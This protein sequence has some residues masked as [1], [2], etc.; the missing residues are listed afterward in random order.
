MKGTVP[1]HDQPVAM[2]NF[3]VQNATG[4]TKQQVVLSGSYKVR[5]S[6]AFLGLAIASGIL[7]PKGNDQVAA[8][9]LSNPEP[10]PAM[11]ASS[12]VA[13][14]SQGYENSA[15]E[16][17][18]SSSDWQPSL[19]KTVSGF[20]P[21]DNPVNPSAHADLELAKP[22]KSSGEA[23]SQPEPQ[24]PVAASESF[25][26]SATL[27]NPSSE[28]HLQFSESNPAE[29]QIAPTLE[30][31][32]TVS[33][34]STVRSYSFSTRQQSSETLPFNPSTSLSQ[35]LSGAFVIP[36]EA[37]EPE[38]GVVYQV[39][40]GDTLDKI[41]QLHDVSVEAI[42]QANRITDP[43]W[44]R[45]NQSLKIP[46]Q[47]ASSFA[48]DLSVP[49]TS[50]G[51]ELP[52]D[53]ETSRSSYPVSSTTDFS[54]LGSRLPQAVAPVVISS[55]A[56][57]QGRDISDLS[58]VPTS[59]TL[60]KLS[61]KQLASIQDVSAVESPV[62]VDSAAIS[63]VGASNRL[64]ESE[65]V[66][67]DLDVSEQK[68]EAVSKLY[69]DRLRAEVERLREEYRVQSD[70][71]V[72]NVAMEDGDVPQVKAL[73][74]VVTSP[75][76]R[77]QRINPEFNPDGY[78]R[79][80]ATQTE[81]SLSAEQVAQLPTAV[82]NQASQLQPQPKQ[83]VVATAPIGANAYDPLSNPALGQMV[84]PQLPPL[85]GPD[86]YLPSDSLRFTGFIWP[87]EGILTSGYGWRWGRMHRGIDI[88][89]P[90]GTPIFAAAP[91]VV[92]YAGWNDGGYGNLVEIEHPD[93]SLTVYAH[94]SRILVNEGQK[95]S[96]GDQISE[97]G[98]TGRSTGPHLHF[99]IHPNGQGAINPMALLPQDNSQVSQDY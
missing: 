41:A 48:G 45:I 5:T 97:M 14:S 64:S 71:K 15:S 43:H 92:T 78:S 19:L 94:N 80:K 31:S 55:D 98:S 20:N 23:F 46:K 52:T 88:A 9:E 53:V 16:G 75:L 77:L 56:N 7:I 58:A 70:Y 67:T 37:T 40:S 60:E 90:V 62:P 47:L 74:S 61:L 51:Q 28:P 10:N 1:N 26:Q 8:V 65:T 11:Q 57:V 66:T 13:A 2:P 21:G 93:G 4:E 81:G 82:P 73:T 68:S 87:A 76:H 6:A 34:S 59:S 72:I 84:S 91:G 38:V 44:L 33:E 49:V 63:I 18:A 30:P 89:G 42:I 39:G 27:S 22:D 85:L 17:S 35:E 54:V 99:E 69:T 24:T 25:P 96:Q 86:A 79:Q 83:S 32:A 29:S 50:R 95:V 3:E 12:P 36:P